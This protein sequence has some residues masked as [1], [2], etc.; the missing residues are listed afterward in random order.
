MVMAHGQ[1]PLVVTRLLK[2]ELLGTLF[3]SAIPYLWTETMDRLF[4]PTER[5]DLL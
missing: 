1:E 2:G 4:T 3:S 5:Q